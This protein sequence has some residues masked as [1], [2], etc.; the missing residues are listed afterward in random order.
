MSALTI[1]PSREDELDAVLAMYEWLFEPPGQRPAAWDPDRAA[2]ALREALGS[3]RSTV[4]V[5]ERDGTLIGLCAA[6]LDLHSVRFGARCWVEDLAVDP[7]H[8]SEG[9]GAALL[10]EAR[11]WAGERG[12]THLE[13]DT[14]E[15]RRDAQRF[16]EREGADHRSISYTWQ[17]GD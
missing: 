7:A 6:Y 9:V 1:R 2:A 15:A 16:Y 13:L 14:A 11:S 8:R 4:L 17:L 5:A 3:D 10:A 12:A